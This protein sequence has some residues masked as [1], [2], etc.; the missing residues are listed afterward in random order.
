MLLAL[1]V[2]SWRQ[3]LQM[4]REQ[5]PQLPAADVPTRRGPGLARHLT[6]VST[7][8]AELNLNDLGASQNTGSHLMLMPEHGF[9]APHITI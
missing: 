8:G 9:L 2:P 7:L 5:L 4:P 3:H 1:E 6:A